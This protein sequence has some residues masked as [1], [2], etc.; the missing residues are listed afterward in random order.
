MRITCFH[1]LAALGFL[2]HPGD[3]VAQ[4]VRIANE[5]G[6]RDEWMLADGV[7]LAAPGYP[8]PF[9]PRGDNVCLAMG[10]RISPDG[11]TGEFTMLRGWSSSGG[12]KEPAEG[13]WDAFSQASASAL[14]QWR[15]KPRPEVGTPRAVDTVATMTFMGKQ[16]Q[17][18]AGLR[19]QCKVDDLMALLEQVRLERAKRSD[20]NRHQLDRAFREQQRSEMVRTPRR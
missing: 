15:F 20:L 13:F 19:A 9:A 6:I 8:A 2:M 11:T 10:Y 14:A 3:S 4:S 16:A 7:K 1:I 5:G 17:D 18:L 12:D